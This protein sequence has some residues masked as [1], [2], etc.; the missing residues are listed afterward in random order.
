M[1]RQF[2]LNSES[3]LHMVGWVY[4]SREIAGK[5][6]LPPLHMVYHLQQGW[7]WLVFMVEVSQG[8]ERRCCKVIQC[9]FCYIP[10]KNHITRAV[11]GQEN[12]FHLSMKTLAKNPWPFLST[13]SVYSGCVLSI[14]IIRLRH[15]HEPSLDT[16]FNILSDWHNVNCSI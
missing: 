4:S 15:L 2:G 8:N 1:G 11:K 10:L 13:N 16:D 9:C 5:A 3:L 12:R 7:C 6:G 14:S